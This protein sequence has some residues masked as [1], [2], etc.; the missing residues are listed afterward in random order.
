ME[1]PIQD[2]E[3]NLAA[4]LESAADG[5]EV[6]ITRD[7]RPVARLEAMQQADTRP[8]NLLQVTEL[9]TVDEILAQRTKL[10]AVTI[11]E[12]LAESRND[13]P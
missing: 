5:Q 4:L 2:V 8:P 1:V 12:L 7:G 3:R 13:L 11:A 9:P 10:S 6:I